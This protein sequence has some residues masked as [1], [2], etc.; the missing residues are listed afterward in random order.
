MSGSGGDAGLSAVAAECAGY[1]D[2]VGVLVGPGGLGEARSGVDDA[3]T[4]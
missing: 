3:G 1:V 4:C 2:G